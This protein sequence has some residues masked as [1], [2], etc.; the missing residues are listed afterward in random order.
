MAPFTSDSCLLVCPVHSKVLKGSIIPIHGINKHEFHLVPETEDGTPVISNI[1]NLLIEKLE[2]LAKETQWL[3][4][5]NLSQKI[6]DWFRYKYVSALIE[7]GFATSKGRIY[8]KEMLSNFIAFYG[9]D[10]LEVVQSMISYECQSNW[11]TS[12]VRKHRKSFHPIRHI[13]IINYLYGSLKEFYKSDSI[14]KPFGDG[15]WPCLN[16]AAEHYLKPVVTNL[17]VSHCTDTKRPVGTFSCNCGFTYSRR[18]PDKT[19]DDKYHIGRVKSFGLVWENKLKDLIKNENLSLR[20]IARQLKVDPNTVKKYANNKSK[21]YCENEKADEVIQLKEQYRIKWS[22]LQ[23]EH[24]SLS[25]T[26]LRK[27]QPAVYAWL[28]RHDRNWLFENSPC[29]ATVSSCINRV[30][31]EQRDK[32]I[33]KSVKKAVDEIL[34][35]DSK[36]EKVSIS[37]IGKRTGLLAL[38]EKHLDKLPLTRQYLESVVETT[39]AFQMRRV[40]WSIKQ[41]EQAGEDIK[42]WKVQR[43]AGIRPECCNHFEF[44]ESLINCR[45]QNKI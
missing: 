8:Q 12:I 42:P 10:F 28:Y 44:I 29:A 5:Q 34:N 25:K 4:N 20:E 27:L 13:L 37:R 40:E 41:M 6:P 22:V 43:L 9:E 14:K 18:G 39:E 23:E 19:I 31:W 32:D 17:K 35:N 15:P 7:K 45:F 3:V 24:K 2:S 38:L 1:E 16:A 30:N 26:A 36:V 21:T 11:L 33:L